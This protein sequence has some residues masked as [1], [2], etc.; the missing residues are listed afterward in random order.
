MYYSMD[1]TKQN[2]NAFLALLVFLEEQLNA[3]FA[4]KY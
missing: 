2:I 4:G 1:D 3:T